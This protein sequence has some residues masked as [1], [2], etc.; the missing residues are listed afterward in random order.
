MDQL[1]L[2]IEQSK[3]NARKSDKE[4]IPD[5]KTALVLSPEEEKRIVKE[6][7][8]ELKAIDE[9]Y[10]SNK[11]L[12][13]FDSLDRQ[14]DGEMQETDGMQFNLSTRTTAI[15]V[16]AVVQALM[17]AF[18]E[19]DRVFSIT[20]R[21]EFEAAENGQELIDGQE[22]FLDYKI[23]EVIPFEEECEP[24]FHS[25]VLKGCGVIKFCNRTEIRKRK[26]NEFY[27]GVK[28]DE[29]GQIVDDSGLKALIRNHPG[30]LEDYPDEV[31]KIME[32]KDLNLV[33]EYDEV[34]YDDPLPKFIDLKDFRVRIMTNKFTGLKD[35]LLI[36]ERKEYTFWELLLE[37]KH[38]HLRNISK[39]LYKN[40]ESE[41]ENRKIENYS[42]E[43][44][45]LW[46]CTFFTRINKND[47]EKADNY[48]KC[49]FHISKER[50]TMHD[51]VFFPYYTIDTNYVPFYIK[52]RKKGFFEDGLG[53]DLTQPNLAENLILNIA[54][55]G[56]YISNIVT[57]IIKK[58]SALAEQF[59][60]KDWTHGMPLECEAGD[61]PDFLSKYMKPSNT[62]ELLQLKAFMRQEGAEI[63]GVNE[64]F[65]TG[66][67]DPIDPQAPASKTIALL[68]RSGINV[69]NYIKRILPSMNECANIIMQMYYQKFQTIE[70]KEMK[71]RFSEERAREGSLFGVMTREAMAAKTNAQ[72][73]ALAFDFNKMNQRKETVALWGMLRQEPMLARNPWAVYQLGKTVIGSFGYFWRN[74][75]RQLWPDPKEFQQQIVQVAMQAIQ[76][77][78]SQETAK[79]KLANREPN[80]DIKSLVGS[81]RQAIS[82]FATPPTPEQIKQREQARDVSGESSV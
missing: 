21:P 6:I 7:L 47:E 52:R 28:K 12:E 32:G 26:L 23:D 81:V 48:T 54:L 69:K 18:F 60:S 10:E 44:Y 75:V 37:E 46:E 49:V 29:S 38:E 19:G 68:E 57:P 78:V 15:K 79:A 34:V 22:D 35:T 59:L 72:S 62:P 33:V 45:E 73:Q 41:K 63:S 80:F 66:R 1:N 31:R 67:A 70:K 30:V 40:D 50:E 9:E 20:P 27:S 13:T 77:V 56:A 25:A 76:A 61:K 39:L 64:S 16:N 53:K 58:G 2:T 74:K 3:K 82:D 8:D 71:Y 51:S 5:Y 36:A 17:D 55:E 24:V 11:I 65:A 43:K 14:Y 42:N 4:E